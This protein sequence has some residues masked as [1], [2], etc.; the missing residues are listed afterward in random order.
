MKKITADDTRKLRDL[1]EGVKRH[2]ARGDY[3]EDTEPDHL[4]ADPVGREMMRRS[5][6]KQAVS[7]LTSHID[8]ILDR[9]DTNPDGD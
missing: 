2:S 5:S 3:G 8:A 7:N 1:N 4:I 9:E 6:A